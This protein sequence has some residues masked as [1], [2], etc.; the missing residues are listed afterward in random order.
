MRIMQVEIFKFDELSDK[1]KEKARDW[2]REASLHDEWYESI[3]EDAAN[4]HIKITGFDIGRGNDI[5]GEFT[6]DPLIVADK[7]LKDHGAGCDTYKTAKIFHAARN[8]LDEQED[9]SA[10]DSEFLRDILQDYLSSLRKEYEHVTS[11]ETI[12]ENICTN[13]YEFTAD[14]KIA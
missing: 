8:K 5:D 10:L 12:D 14:G 7:I 3:Y 11:D 6:D 1:A 13:E 9:H 4:V 2:Y